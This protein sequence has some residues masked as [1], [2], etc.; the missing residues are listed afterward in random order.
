MS[1]ALDLAHFSPRNSV[2]WQLV[3]LEFGALQILAGI[4]CRSAFVDVVVRNAVVIRIAF[5]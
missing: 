2:R 5:G 4:G 1:D 3:D